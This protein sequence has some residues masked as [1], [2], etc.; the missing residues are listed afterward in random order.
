MAE[1]NVGHRVLVHG[2]LSGTVSYVGS[3]KFADGQ[4]VGVTLDRPLGKNNGTIRG[5]DY[6]KCDENHGIFVRMKTLSE[7]D[8]QTHAV[9]QI[10][11][12]TRGVQARKRTRE[13]RNVKAWNIMDNHYEDLHV[14]KGKRVLDAAYEVATSNTTAYSHEQ[15]N[16]KKRRSQILRSKRVKEIESI[17]V[18]KT[19]KGVHVGVNFE[20]EAVLKLLEQ[21]KSGIPLHFKYVVSIV[22]RFRRESAKY[23]CVQHVTIPEN[24]TLTVVGDLHGQLQDLYTIFT[25]NGLPDEKNC[26]LFNGDFVDRGSCGIEIALVLF[27]FKMLY[28]ESIFINRGNHEARAQNSWMG[29]EEEVF[30]KYHSENEVGRARTLYNMF[31]TC[32]DHLSLVTIINAKVFVCHGGLFHVDGVKL[33][34]LDSIRRKRE[35]PLGGKSLE[36]RLFEDLLWSDPRPSVTYPQKLSGRVASARGA[37]VE[38]GPDVTEKFCAENGFALIIRSHECVSEGYE[39]QHNGRLITVFSASRYCGTQTNKGAFITFNS[40]VQPEIQQYYAHS[41]DL[42]SFGKDREHVRQ[43]L[44]EDDLVRMIIERVCDKKTDLYWYFTKQDKEH[45]GTCTR[46]EWAETMRTVLNLELPYLSLQHLICNADAETG[47]INYTDFLERYRFQMST[48]DYA[49]VDKIMKRVNH[50]LFQICGD[51]EEAFALFD[52]DDDGLIEYDEFLKTFTSLDCG[53]TDKQAYELM[54]SIDT[55]NN[56]VIDFKEFCSRFQI[57]FD[58]VRITS[59]GNPLEGVSSDAHENLS[60]VLAQKDQEGNTLE[61]K[62][63]TKSNDTRRNNRQRRS[64]SIHDDAWVQQKLYHIAMLLFK[65]NYRLDE[66]FA[67]FDVDGSGEISREEFVEA[68]NALGFTLNEDDALRIFAAVDHADSQSIS[69]LEFINA[70]AVDDTGM[71]SNSMKNRSSWQD[72]IIQMVANVLFQHRVQLLSAFRLFDLDNSGQINSDDFKTAMLTVNSIFPE[73][74]SIS[75]IEELRYALLNSETKKINYKDFLESFQI[76]DVGWTNSL[77]SSSLTREK[78]RRG[79]SLYSKK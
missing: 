56:G 7:Y 40:D 21:F 77:E 19:Y 72:S 68:L 66:A 52:V 3:T 73:P 51:V 59:D 44:L 49:W 8:I 31:E 79:S 78:R 48:G 55:D 23:P 67:K 76:V 69:Y 17:V 28:P 42:N 25:I 9:N 32:F 61:S 6:F 58:K 35:P 75:Q 15:Q 70:F 2:K 12:I 10:Q 47:D 30:G 24:S 22:D 33:E 27:C 41:L 36:D 1:F 20:L 4:W 57:V 34:H 53:L 16:D 64:S 46:S 38:F 43:Q 26:Y 18:E 50:K 54:R 62:I 71:N 45:K 65:Q 74:L 63:E 5:E 11:T 13:K 39:I 14:K 60:T 37:G 29:F